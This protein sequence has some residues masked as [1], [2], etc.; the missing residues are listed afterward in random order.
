M[1][2]IS[3]KQRRINSELAKIKVTLGTR[4]AICG[5]EGHDLSHILPRS[6]YPEYQ[7]DPRNLQ[8]LCREC[9][10][11]FDDDRA[12]RRSQTSIVER[13]KMIDELATNRYFGL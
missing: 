4:C 13:A 5:R 10:R 7:T 2:Q 12:F 8:I 3:S 11:R 9:H 6:L 1:K